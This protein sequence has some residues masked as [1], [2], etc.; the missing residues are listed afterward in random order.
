MK[1]LIVLALALTAANAGFSGFRQQAQPVVQQAIN[2]VRADLAAKAPARSSAEVSFQT[3]FVNALNNHANEILNQIDNT[4][5]AVNA[6]AQGVVSQFHAAVSQLQALGQSAVESGQAII[7]NLVSGL[8]GSLFGKDRSGRAI[9]AFLKP[10]IQQIATNPQFVS[11]VH[12]SDSYKCLKENGLTVTFEWVQQL[13]QNN[14]LNADLLDDPVIAHCIEQG[15]GLESI[16]AGSQIIDFVE[17]IVEPLGLSALIDQTIISVLGEELGSAIIAAINSR[18]LFGDIWNGVSNAA[19]NIWDGVSG[20][21]VNAWNNL[22]QGVINVGQYIATLATETFNSAAEKFE[23]IKQLA[24]AFLQGAI[25]TAHFATQQAAQEFINYLSE[26]A[27]DLGHLYDNVV[28]QLT[29][30]WDGLYI[31]TWTSRQA[32]RSA[33]A[34]PA[35]LKPIVQQVATNPQFVALVHASSSYKCLKENGLTV[36]FEWVQH[37]SQNNQLNADLLNDPVIAHCLDQA[38]GLENV[39]AGSQIID[40]VQNFLKPFGLTGAIHNIILEVLGQE[41]GSVVINAMNSRHAGRSARAI[42]A[43][44][45]PIVQQI[46][47]NP[48]FVALVHASSSY[49]CLKENGLTVTFEWVQHLSQNNQLNADLLNDPVIA[50][51]LDQAGGLENVIAGSQII[52]WVQNFLKPFGLTSAI[53]N[54]ILEVLG[55][56]L[57]SVVINAMNSRRV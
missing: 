43:Y 31:P 6:L 15:G 16:V 44:L 30:I 52:D 11:M 20:A 25:T 56:E 40:W 49:K 34:I 55:Q 14:Q 9:P 32:A 8:F 48:Q 26:F 10:I 21:A 5:D 7:G 2:K 41:L 3:E 42:P 1:V 50:H 51:C 29:A 37:L 33:R 24:V 53:H 45:K 46:A 18:G 19:V 12:N 39:I 28:N 47:T 38:G 13:S 27:S 36:T 22:S 17:A 57:G 35:Y 23:I 4:V 54:I